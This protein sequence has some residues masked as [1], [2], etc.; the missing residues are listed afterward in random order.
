MKRLRQ[1]IGVALMP[2]AGFS[3]VLAAAASGFER[4]L[5][6]R[7]GDPY[8]VLG[9]VGLTPKDIDQPTNIISLVTYCRMLETAA[10]SLHDMNF[11]LNYGRQF[12]PEMF[13]L[14]GFVALASPN[15]GAA[16]KNFIDLFPLHQN[17]TET[18]VA[19]KGDF[20]RMEYRILDEKIVCRRQDA[21]FTIAAFAN[22]AKRCLGQQFRPVKVEFEHPQPS[23]ASDHHHVF[24][25]EVAFSQKTNALVMRVSN[26]DMPLPHSNLQLLDV[27]RCS[28]QSVACE[29]SRVDLVTRVRAEIRSRLA[30]QAV[31]L[32]MV[33]DALSMPRWNLQRRLADE[34]LTYSTLVDGVRRDLAADYIGQRHI[35]LSEVAYLLGYSEL[36]AFSR[37][38]RKWHEV[39]PQSFRQNLLKNRSVFC[40]A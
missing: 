10:A 22:V 7:G 16:L 9:N 6:Q 14:I 4:Y 33:A 28:L 40:A 1:T 29:H 18:R 35:P 24:D 36:S 13:G 37:A 26:L 8:A 25:T 34:G 12:E 17:G 2:V 11:G 3:Q 32:E 38:F 19:M 23:S 15:V 20:L 31:N 21:E 27:L 30:N 5:G 39:S